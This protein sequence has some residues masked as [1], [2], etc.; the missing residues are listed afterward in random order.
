MISSMGDRSGTQN[1]AV[2]W[3]P[4]TVPLHLHGHRKKLQFIWSS[5]ERYRLDRGLAPGQVRVLEVGCS[6]GRNITTPLARYGY[7]ITGLD[8][9]RESIEYARSQTPFPN[10]RFLCEDL[11]QLPESERFEVIILS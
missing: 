3:N 5:I 6:N 2:D 7:E 4:D 8:I 1:T 11:A 10:A 9:H